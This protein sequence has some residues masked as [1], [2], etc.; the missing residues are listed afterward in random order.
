MK[1]ESTDHQLTE[2]DESKMGTGIRRFK[3][4]L[5]T[6]ICAQTVCDQARMSSHGLV[7]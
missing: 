1:Q 2:N 3:G 7:D 6:V 5:R 4:T